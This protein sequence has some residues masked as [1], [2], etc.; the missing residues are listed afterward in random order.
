MQTRDWFARSVVCLGLGSILAVFSGLSCAGKQDKVRI[1]A[2]LPLSGPVASFGQECL[3]GLQI[4]RDEINAKGGVL[5]KKIELVLADTEGDPGETEGAVRTLIYT[6]RVPLIIGEVLSSN[7]LV[8]APICQAAKVPLLSPGSTNPRV[9][10]VGD[11]ISRVCF[12]DPFQGL[13][14]ANFARNTLKARTAI[15]VS[16]ANSDYSRG[17]AEF[18]S[19]RFRELNGEILRE[20][21]YV[22]GA[23]DFS[24]DI[25]DI[26]QFQPDC[27]FVPGYYIEAALFIKQ[28]RDQGI[29]TTFLGGD[30]WDS[31]RLFEL[32][33]DAIEGC[34]ITTHFSAQDQDPPVQDFVRKYEASYKEKPGA[35]AALGYDALK[36]AAD[37]IGRARSLDRTAIRD[38]VNSTKGVKG[39]TGTITLDKERDAIKD[40]V[41]LKVAGRKFEFVNRVRP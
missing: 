39:V 25:D 18:F 6:E 35:L 15:V 20:I 28:A 16:D 2:L 33:G 40:V 32:G 31:P 13:A 19:K 9:T 21:W 14:M 30:G 22:Q 29:R 3:K 26:K 12:S 5:G 10:Q 7:S 17:L 11:Y 37:A 41:V 36:V 27:V 8:A 1:G 4:A 24:P 38:A 23:T 34:F